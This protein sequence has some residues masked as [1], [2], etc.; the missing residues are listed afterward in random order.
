MINVILNGILNLM[1]KIIDIIMTPINLIIEKTLPD[2][3]NCIKAIASLLNII[4][5]GLA[6]AV[7]ATGLNGETI[8]TMVMFLT[9]KLT[10]PFLIS[11][12]KLAIKLYNRLKP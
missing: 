1:I 7:S 5:S 4:S 11:S 2:L 6:L 8:G 10:A 9:F 12:I 3:S